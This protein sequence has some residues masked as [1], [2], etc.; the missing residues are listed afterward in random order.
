MG[1]T[2]SIRK[3]EQEFDLRAERFICKHP[4]LDFFSF[5]GDANIY[6]DLCL[7]QHND[8]CSADC[9]AAWLPV[10]FI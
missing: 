3:F 7:Y 8:H 9:V 2:R 10:T 6:F 5:C 1:I 4:L